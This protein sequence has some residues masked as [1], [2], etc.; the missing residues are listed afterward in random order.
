VP[1]AILGIVVVYAIA[2]FADGSLANRSG[3]VEFAILTSVVVVLLFCRWLLARGSAS[4]SIGVTEGTRPGEGEV[5]AAAWPPGKFAPTTVPT[6]PTV[7]TL[8]T[9]PRAWGASASP[10]T[11]PTRGSTGSTGSTGARRWGASTVEPSAPIAVPSAPAAVPTA[12][13][14]A[15]VDHRPT[16][17]RARETREPRSVRD[18]PS[19][20][21]GAGATSALADYLDGRTELTNLIASVEARMPTEPEPGAQPDA[22]AEPE[23][24][25]SELPVV[26][27]TK[28]LAQAAEQ[29]ARACELIAHACELLAERVESDRL[30]R[31]T[32]ADAVLMLAQQATPAAS[33]PRLVNARPTRQRAIV[34]NDGT[35]VDLQAAA[36]DLGVATRLP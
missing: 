20:F 25:H 23:A 9:V 22:A 10:A 3:P 11:T 15:T 5:R 33:T 21:E 8:P 4:P 29:V 12:P 14:A 16:P 30:E 28:V 13:A 34:E 19:A 7:P 1:V 27:S 32:L 2:S 35:S 31:R 17:E 24:E 36:G 18:T 6:M 26:P